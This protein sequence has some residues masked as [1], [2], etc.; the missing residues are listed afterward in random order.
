MDTENKDKYGTPLEVGD[1]ICFNISMGRS[2][3]ILT[4]AKITGFHERAGFPLAS[5]EFA[6]DDKELEWVR[7]G[8]KLPKS[9]YLYRVIKCY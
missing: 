3:K 5:L 6:E 7:I 4:K 9:V 8:N 1:Y 2:E